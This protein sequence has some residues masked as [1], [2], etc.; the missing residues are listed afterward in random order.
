MYKIHE[1]FPD[2]E[3]N[4]REEDFYFNFTEAELT[5]LQFSELGGLAAMI[6]K[7]TATQ[8][9]P[10]LMQLFEEI[11]QKSYGEKTADGRG[12]HKSA[13]LTQSFTETEAYSQIYMRLATDHKAAQDFINHVIPKKMQEQVKQAQ[14][15]AIPM[16]K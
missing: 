6:R 7:I 10:K 16:N 8:D 13:E 11:L 4:E 15:N 1:K 12:F 2:Y 3:G 14:T 5:H 9:T